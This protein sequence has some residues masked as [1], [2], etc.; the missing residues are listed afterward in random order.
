MHAQGP[1]L[2]ASWDMRPLAVQDYSVSG[3]EQVVVEAEGEIRVAE[4]EELALLDTPGRC[5]C[6]PIDGAV[7]GL[8]A[9]AE[10]AAYVNRLPPRVA[11]PK[12][13]SCTGAL[14]LGEQVSHGCF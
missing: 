6:F 1:Q 10:L 4:E 2:A 11:A 7:C 9:R 3:D 12:L 8:W 14:L 13:G 5:C